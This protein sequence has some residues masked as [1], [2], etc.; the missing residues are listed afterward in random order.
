[1]V[2]RQGITAAGIIFKRPNTDFQH[3]DT[4]VFV[5]NL[6]KRWVC[7]PPKPELEGQSAVGIKDDAGGDLVEDQ[8]TLARSPAAEG[9]VGYTF[10]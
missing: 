4:Y 1:M 9:W 2:A 6:Q 5:V 7:F 8:I 10:C 3:G